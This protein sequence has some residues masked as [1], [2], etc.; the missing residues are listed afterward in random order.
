M[1]NY[2]NIE[3]NLLPPE[4]QPA[5]TVRTAVILNFAI[6][7]G[8]LAYILLGTFGVFNQIRNEQQRIK[9]NQGLIE[10]KQGVVTIYGQLNDAHER[11]ERYGRLVS[12]ASVDYIDV[13]VLLDRLA[14]IVPAGVYLNSV[15]NDKSSPNSRSTVV[16][17]T[18]NTTSNDPKLVQTTLDAFKKDSMFQDSY[19]RSAELQKVTLNDQLANFNVDWTATGPSVPASVEVDKYQFIVMANVPKLVDTAGLPVRA[20]R[21]IYLADVEFKTP[22][23]PEEEDMD[24][25][26]RK[27]RKGKGD[28][29]EA[30]E[31]E[32]NADNA[33]EGVKPVGVN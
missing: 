14:K 33:P 7:L 15:N 9:D 2:R 4:L 21:S 5:P 27:S 18:L 17:V 30:R 29:N 6:V 12:L 32:K 11:V 22:P 31:P 1:S 19:M 8:V 3:V 13:P 23:P 26:P 20:D 28:A 16:Q 25:K 10:S 24:G